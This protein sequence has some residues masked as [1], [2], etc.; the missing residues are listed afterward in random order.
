MSDQLL[1]SLSVNLL[2]RVTSGIL[3]EISKSLSALGERRDN[4]FRNLVSFCAQ[5]DFSGFL[6]KF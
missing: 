4:T 1:T 6:Q 5:D 3:K 2:F